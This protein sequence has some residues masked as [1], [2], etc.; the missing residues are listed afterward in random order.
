MK[1]N[2]A[3]AFFLCAFCGTSFAVI[4]FTVDAPDDETSARVWACN[5][6]ESK[7][8]HDDYT[9]I[10]KTHLWPLKF[11]K[12]AKIFGPKLDTATNWWGSGTNG[13]GERSGPG[14]DHRPADRVLPIFAA[15]GG[16]NCGGALMM[17]VS[18]LHSND[19]AQNKSH[20]DLYAVGDIGYV[21]F[22]SHLNGEK[23]QT[24]VIYFRSDFAFIPLKST[25]DFFARLEWEKN[26][27]DALKE[28]FDGHLAPA[29]DTRKLFPNAATQSTK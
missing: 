14:L 20:T 9:D 6:P 24:A 19:P 2:I 12:M 3:I 21:E 11:S 27:F 23:V 25:N 15:G 16:T 28:W 4:L 7:T 1:R 29:Y 26:K 18:G 10:I 13:V 17:M 5:R 8:L 22:Y